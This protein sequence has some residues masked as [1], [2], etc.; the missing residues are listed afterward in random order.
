MPAAAPLDVQQSSG[1]RRGGGPLTGGGVVVSPGN[2]Y[3]FYPYRFHG[4]QPIGQNVCASQGASA[5]AG[6]TTYDAI[7][8]GA[9]GLSGDYQTGTTASGIGGAGG[10]LVVLMAPVINLLSGAFLNSQ[11]GSG[12]AGTG[13]NVNGGGGGGGGA[14]LFIC[15]Q[16][17]I[18]GTPSYNA[19][20]GSGGPLTGTGSAGNNGAAGNTTP[21]VV[22]VP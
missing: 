18:T 4:G 5:F 6:S 1:Q 16:L 8:G 21:Y 3:K 17:N 22:L 10:A 12:T 19:A 2:S 9:A 13:T 20:G 7:K 15:Q 14:F 11:G